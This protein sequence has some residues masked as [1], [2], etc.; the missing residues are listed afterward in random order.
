VG[1]G[2]ACATTIGDPAEL[3]WSALFSAAAQPLL[4]AMAQAKPTAKA[5]IVRFMIA[6][7]IMN[8]FI[9]N[10]SPYRFTAERATELALLQPTRLSDHA[11]GSGAELRTT[12]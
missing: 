2:I 9:M 8:I 7:P 10:S 1:F 6:L 3:W 4:I 11:L 5:A 12:I